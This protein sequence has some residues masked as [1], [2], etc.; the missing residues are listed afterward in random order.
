MENTFFYQLFQ[1]LTAAEVRQF[2]KFAASPYFNGRPQLCLLLDY[3]AK[4]GHQPAAPDPEKAFKAAFPAE[5]YDDQ[6][7]RLTLSQLFKLAEQFIA[8]QELAT[9]E[10]LGL[11]LSQAYRKRGLANHFQRT[12]QKLEKQQE[13]TETRSAG[14][15]ENQYKIA[16]EKYRSHSA[17]KRTE[18]FNLQEVSDA[19]DA[20]FIARKLRH[21]CFSLSHQAVYQ[22][23]YR[24]GL[25]DEILREVRESP[26][27]LDSPAINLYY[28]CFHALK[29]GS[30]ESDF[31][32][33]KNLL[34]DQGHLLP[35]EEQRNLF[36]L[37]INNG[38]RQINAG[39]PAY[40]RPV[41][42]LYRT[43][44][45]NDLLL[46]NGHLSRFAFNNIVAIAVRI[47]ET[48]WVENFIHQYK[49][50]LEREHRNATFSLNLARLQY[51]R[52]NYKEALLQ[53]QHSDYKDLINNL[54]AKT[55]QL[56]IYYETNEYE[57]LEAHLRNMK[58]YI[59]RQRAIGYHKQ[60]YLN[61]I[62]FTQALVEMNPFAKKEHTALRDAILN[63]RSLTEKD[64]LLDMMDR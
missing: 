29:T 16:W 45:D 51:T 20:A 13:S 56:K 46:E 11:S 55:L 6:K 9:G 4:N 25:L 61:I 32:V 48:D 7:W 34:F 40:D 2:R 41:L 24:F 22:A 39:R 27:L 17:G 33:F 18:A 31:E 5:Q 62:R 10:N 37:A 43:A 50:S 47:G 64:W 30:G 19:M 15:H 53:L 36:L 44:L 57:V 58:T 42:D 52:K 28:H 59:R 54:I 60:N 35:S 8:W 23:E 3:F 38:I 21:V 63:E 49:N 1:S 26:W 12:I 14:F